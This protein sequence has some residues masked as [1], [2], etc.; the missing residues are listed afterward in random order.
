MLGLYA[1]EAQWLDS[2]KAV[3]EKRA[4]DVHDVAPAQ[5]E[6]DAVSLVGD[7]VMTVVSHVGDDGTMT[8][9]S[10]VGGDSTMTVVLSHVG[11]AVVDGAVHVVAVP[12]RVSVFV[13]GERPTNVQHYFHLREIQVVR[14]KRL[15]ME[16]E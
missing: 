16:K 7:G 2:R 11:Y 1:V 9:V 4:V 5:C 6:F 14:V 8:V 15:A 10:P 13:L 3:E 12:H